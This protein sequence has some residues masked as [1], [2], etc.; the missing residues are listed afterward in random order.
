MRLLILAAAALL[1]LAAPVGAQG[2]NP[3]G[4]I[5]VTPGTVA[6]GDTVRVVVANCEAP[7]GRI[8]TVFIDG[9]EVGT[10]EI[11]RTGGFNQRFE[12]PEEAAGEVTV[13]VVGCD[14][15][16]LSSVI[17]V[18]TTDLPFQDDGGPGGQLPLTGSSTTIPLAQLGAALL[19]VGAILLVVVARRRHE[20]ELVPRHA[21]SS[22][23][24]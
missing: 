14:N 17:T 21:V 7:A 4:T 24:G 20:D 11:N 6:P 18:V 9:V 2:Y 16:V 8:V 13:E 5:V 15:G 1:T 22:R 12:V 10:A 3:P 23:H 19:G